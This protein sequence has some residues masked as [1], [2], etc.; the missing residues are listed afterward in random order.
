MKEGDIVLKK[1]E[2]WGQ[3]LKNLSPFGMKYIFFIF[4]FLVVFVAISLP[5]ENYSGITPKSKSDLLDVKHKILF[6]VAFVAT[7]FVNLYMF[8]K[9]FLN[10]FPSFI[11]KSILVANNNSIGGVV[12]KGKAKKTRFFL[13]IMYLVVLIFFLSIPSTS[14]K[15]IWMNQGNVYFDFL[16]IYLLCVSFIVLNFILIIYSELIK[17][18]K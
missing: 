18:V 8:A 14:P 7:V 10:G 15:Y 3:V 17:N 12:T 16:F 6:D 13:F 11:V 5:I 1:N 2:I 4:V 9:Y